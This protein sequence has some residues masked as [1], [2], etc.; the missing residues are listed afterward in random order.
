MKT[1]FMQF[2]VD[3]E[4][5]QLLADGSEVHL[6]PKAFDLLCVLLTRRPNVVGKEQLLQ[7]VWPNT[8]VTEANLNVLVAEVR[9]AVGDSPQTPRCIRTVHGVGY[10]FCA[11][12]ADVQI[13][14][15][16]CWLIADDR[17]FVLSDGDNIIGRD[18]SCSVWLDDPDVSR[19]HARI[20]IDSIK[21][22]A[23]IED[24]DSTNGTTIGKS[25]IKKETA[26]ADG[27][28]IRFGPVQLK[29]R[30]GSDTPQVTRRIRRKVE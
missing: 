7:L 29:F 28:V 12:A 19:R 5:R 27:D 10:A 8:Y 22:S 30:D 23:L 11:A 26:L 20:R 1:R 16:R 13:D 25:A 2:I 24:L 18:P 15:G 6:S 21:K 4:T 14:H 17:R 9:R 3:S